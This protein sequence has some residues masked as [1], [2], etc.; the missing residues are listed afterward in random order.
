MAQSIRVEMNRAGAVALLRS[1]AVM[2]DLM[3]RGQA[4]AA[5][6][7]RGHM[8]TSYTGRTRARVSVITS[9][10]SARRKEA[11]DRNLTRALNAARG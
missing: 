10:D 3:R 1:P 2:A 8:V 9:T 6:A 11:L 7:G 4:V 5:A